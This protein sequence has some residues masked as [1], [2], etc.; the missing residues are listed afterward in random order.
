MLSNEDKTYIKDTIVFALKENNKILWL[1]MQELA[2]TL[3]QEMQEISDSLRQEMQEL[4]GTLRQ[5]FKEE[6]TKKNGILLR[7]ISD[8]FYTKSEAAS[9]QDIIDAVKPLQKQISEL[10]DTVIEMHRDFSI[11]ITF[12]EGEIKQIKHVVQI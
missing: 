9:K 3:R 2:G 5:E 7:K 4:A 8:S 1:E 6:I 10:T 12:N 11:R